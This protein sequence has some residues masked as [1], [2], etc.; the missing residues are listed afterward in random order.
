MTPASRRSNCRYSQLKGFTLYATR[1]ILSGGEE[2]PIELAKAD[3]RELK[4]E[5]TTP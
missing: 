1:A 2:E 3:L 5:I 4:A